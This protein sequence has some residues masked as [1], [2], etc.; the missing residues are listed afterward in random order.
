M[1]GTGP[2][3]LALLAIGGVLAVVLRSLAAPAVRD[4]PGGFSTSRARAHVAVIAAEPHPTG[5]PANAA[6]RDYLLGQ[7]SELGLEPSVEP[8]TPLRPVD[9]PGLPVLARVHNLTAS[10]PGEP[11]LPTVVLMAHY[12][13]VPTAPGAADDAAGVA[14][15]LEVAR[16]LIADP[17][18]RGDLRIVLTDGEELGL[19]GALAAVPDWPCDPERTVVLNFEARGVAGPAIMFETGRS[20]RAVRYLAGARRPIATSVAAEVYRR[21]PNNTDFSE[22]TAAGFDGLNFALIRGSA[23]Y[24]TAGDRPSRLS[25][26]SLGHLGETALSAAR[27]AYATPLPDGATTGSASGRSASGGSVHFPV[28]GRLARY[29]QWLSAVLAIVLTGSFAAAAGIAAAS[30][31]WLPRAGIAALGVLGLMV[32]AVAA[33]LAFWR[34]ARLARPELASF[35]FGDS[36]RS[37]WYQAGMLSL[38]AGAVLLAGIGLSALTGQRALALGCWAVLV[39]LAL[40]CT[41]LAPGAAYLFGWPALLAPLVLLAGIRDGRIA[42]GG[43]LPAWLAA[44]LA[45]TVLFTPIIALLLPTNGLA[46][47]SAPL[48]LLVPPLLLA[49]G[50]ARPALAGPAGPITAA[51]LGVAGLLLLGAGYLLDRVDAE[52][53]QHT[54]LFYLRDQHTGR[55]HWL[56][57]D[58]RPP[59]WTRQFA[60]SERV[61]RDDAPGLPALGLTGLASRVQVAAAP[62]ADLPGARWSCQQQPLGAG[63]CLTLRLWPSAPGGRLWLR[64]VAAPDGQLSELL[65][66]GIAV[67][68]EAAGFGFL[69][70]PAEGIEVQLRLAGP[71]PVRLELAAHRDGLPADLLQPP[72]PAELTFSA[73]YTGATVVSD[74]IVV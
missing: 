37:G 33:G 18:P 2:A 69:A 58:P 24:H 61:S 51:A 19:L 60:G 64:L 11:T 70:V 66:E 55:A 45:A 52:H 22:V 10:L 59:A 14:T 47:L 67:P 20:G 6:V 1:T 25:T 8:R 72:M 57:D 16:A 56:S 54:G 27:R 5:S 42:D 40:L 71:E 9:P 38:V 68:V 21:L 4:R 63:R 31:V 65:V 17:A 12:D 13:S 53:P 46:G 73:L 34:L 15:V 36:Y 43:W 39:L 23:Y 41:A 50:A 74:Q 48:A 49:Y 32:A 7:L 29:P 26:A 28:V 3:L 35:E 62:A 44:A 30:G